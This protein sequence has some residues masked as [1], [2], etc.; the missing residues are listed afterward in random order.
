MDELREQTVSLLNFRTPHVEHFSRRL[1]FDTI[2][3]IDVFE[4]DGFTREEHKMIFE[5][6]K[7][8]NLPE[9]PVC[10]TCVRVPVF[11]GHA[12]SVNAEFERPISV[13][14]AGELLSSFPGVVFHPDP[15]NFPVAADVAEVDEV[16]I[17]RL[18]A[19]P[20]VPNGLVFWVVADNLRKGAA[21]NAVQ[22]AEI[23]HQDGK[24]S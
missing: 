20:S 7:I 5:T 4:D 6:R 19:D 21:T 11:V 22:I 3:Q 15:E 23:L 13:E 10:A 24:L 17:G 18:R 2:P 14:K 12:M 8:M 1:A 9:L 16:H